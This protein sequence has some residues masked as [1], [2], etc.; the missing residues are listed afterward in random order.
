M[1]NAE[2]IQALWKNTEGDRQLQLS[3]LAYYQGRENIA[4]LNELRID[5]RTKSKIR[6][7][8]VRYAVRQHAGFLLGERV[9]YV[10]H[11]QDKATGDAA[12]AALMRAYDIDHWGRADYR[13]MVQAMLYKYGVEVL[14]F[15]GA[16]VRSHILPSYEWALSFDDDERLIVALHR[17]VLKK[18]SVYRGEVLTEE[19]RIITEYDA[20]AITTWSVDKDGKP[21]ELESKPH[22]YGRI[23]VAVYQ[24]TDDASEFFSEAFLRQSDAYTVT[25]GALNDDISFNVDSLLMTKG[26]SP[27]ELLET[28]D[29]GVSNVQKLKAAGILPLPENAEAEYLTRTVDIEKFR[30]DMKVSRASIHLMAALPDLDETIGGNDGTITN[31]SGIALRLLFHAMELQSEEFAR[32]FEIGLRDRVEFFGRVMTK[33]SELDAPLERYEIKYNRKIPQNVIEWLQYLG[34]LDGKLSVE[35]QLKQLPFVDDVQ[36]ALA[37]VKAEAAEKLGVAPPESASRRPAGFAA[38]VAE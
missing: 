33:R 12:M 14:R 28:D 31:I 8:W 11:D 21:T 4:E 17:A 38:S 20:D 2:G 13:L 32:N 26:L 23:P 29:D 6:T 16:N 36:G 19:R 9:S 3:R 24:V 34:N 18:G 35:D 1:L 27:K 7:N 10:H 37:R 25:R 15:D 30:E 22:S 5:G